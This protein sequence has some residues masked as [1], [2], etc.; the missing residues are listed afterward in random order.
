MRWDR[1]P[2]ALLMLALCTARL[3]AQTGAT[4]A[5]TTETNKDGTEAVVLSPFVVQSEKDRGYAAANSISGSRVNTAI[6]DIPIPIHVITSEFI[7]DIGATDLRQSLSYVAGITLQSQNDLEN[8]GA[9]F[10]GVYGPGGVN[11]PEGVTS[12]INQVQMK[13]R[14]FVTN[15][16]LRDGFLR[17]NGTDAI[18]IERIEVVFGPN[19]LLYGTGNFGGVV[20]YLT[21]QPRDKAEGMFTASYGSYNFRRA[22]AEVTGPIS[23]AAGLSYR[24]SG[25]WE[26]SKTNIDSQSNSHY[27]LAPTLSWKPTKTTEITVEGEYGKS[28]QNGYGFRALRAAQGNSATP[29]NN[30]QLEAVSFYWP[31]GANPRTFNLSGP[32]TFNDQQQSNL[33]IK[34][35]QEIT[36]ES[37]YVPQID[38]L[39]GYNH[40]RFSTQTQNLNGQIT[41]PILAGQPG[42][43][44]SDTIVTLG[45]TNGLGGQGVANGNLLFGTLP[46]SVVK[47]AWGQANSKQTRDQERV[48]TTLKKTLFE[49]HW[50]QISEQLL[51]GYS[52]IMNNTTLDSTATIPGAYSYKNPNDL[53]PIVYGTQGDGSPDPATYVND[54][55][56]INKG[57][58]SAY[59][60]N[61]YTKLFKFGGVADRVIIMNGLRRDKND[62]WSTDTNL[63]APTATPSTTVSRSNQVVARSH[64][65]GVILKLTEELSIYGLKSEGFQPN[66][67]TQHSA[68]TGAP[69]GA[70]TAK[71]KEFGVKFDLFK[72]K[73]SGTISRYKITKTGWTGAPWFSPA[74]LGH[75][76]F[77]ATKP[78]VYNLEGGFNGNTA[79]NPFPGVPPTSQGAPVQTD[80]TVVAAWNAAVAAGAVTAKSPLTGKSFDANSLYLNAS[81]PTGSAYMD[82]AF[83]SVGTNGG[84]WPGWPYQGNSNNDPNI[85]NAT[86]D[87]AGFQN[88][89]QNAANQVI[90]EAKGWDGTLL[91]TPNDNLQMI[92]TATLE[93]S[94]TRLSA[95]Q[96]PK[97]PS[98][99]DRWATWYFPNGGF[100]LQGSPLATAYGD[101]S[102]TS[103]HKQNLFP[104]DDTPAKSLSA[105]IKYKFSKGSTLQGFSIGLGG[106]WHSGGVAFSGITHG[107]G[108]AQY[109]TA[110][111]LLVLRTPSLMLVNS[112]AKYEWKSYGY[113]QYVQFNVDNL[114]NNTK[115]YGLIYQ[116]PLTAKMSYGIGF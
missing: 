45:A 94:V 35:T 101:P 105:L 16:T 31:P 89:P 47:Y 5:S 10:G 1:L 91:F 39:A 80:P 44:L 99:N 3:T 2:F 49:G 63:S 36:K 79:A 38:F 77:D 8:S 50:Y 22:T 68:A 86:M 64:Q 84:A 111:Q 51:G 71:S 24:M 67:T 102:D 52:E 17:G 106:N 74:P 98:Y 28:K 104:G 15:N 26:S 53:K 65:N 18:N 100:G 87:A 76:R 59:Y 29:I 96:Y 115:L 58:D 62:N 34:L 60:L 57:W 14:G 37:D 42:Y 41:G 83:A 7:D 11:N 40:S 109:N 55:D 48:E 32:N 114:L 54:H 78:V 12:N 46:N 30:D 13:V 21:K 81:T 82:A 69:V 56:N 4:P 110:G 103:T 108:Q 107:G 6:K 112:F 75:V 97:Y 20:D 116:T 95:G 27:F 92:M 72:G 43:A 85:N 73:L 9:A 19:A 23:A 61:S 66:F 113:N 90:D 70:D 88:G 33:E 93:T 25:A